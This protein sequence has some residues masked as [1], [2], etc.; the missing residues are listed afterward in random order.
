MILCYAF[1][2]RFSLKKK[3]KM[4]FLAKHQQK[5]LI[6]IQ[7]ILFLFFFQFT[8]YRKQKQKRILFFAKHR[9]KIT[10]NKHSVSIFFISLSFLIHIDRIYL[11]VVTQFTQILHKNISNIA[12]SIQQ[13]CRCYVKCCL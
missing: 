4:H 10:N 6:T 2:M 5:S 7:M 9:Q 13:I 3:Q 8:F 1:T 12:R 11:L